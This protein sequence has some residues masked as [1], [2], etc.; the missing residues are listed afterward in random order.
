MNFSSTYS[1]R[2]TLS[3]SFSFLGCPTLNDTFLKIETS[4]S[5]FSLCYFIL[6]TELTKQHYIKSRAGI[7][8]LHLE[9]DGGSNIFVG[10]KIIFLKM[11]KN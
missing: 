4:H 9:W 2:P 7:E 6:S 1:L 10:E 11:I 3:E 8:M 5:I